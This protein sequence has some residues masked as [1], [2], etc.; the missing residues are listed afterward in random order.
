MRKPARLQGY[1]DLARDG[2]FVLLSQALEGGLCSS[3]CSFTQGLI[4]P[5]L[6]A[7][8]PLLQRRHRARRL[9]GELVEGL[10]QPE[11]DPRAR[12]RLTP[13]GRFAS[14]VTATGSA[15]ATAIDV[16]PIM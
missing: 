5:A 14:S 15:T 7:L 10:L 4:D 16:V 8:Y 11:W 2:K 12:E 13:P 9:F 1:I 6:I 3:A